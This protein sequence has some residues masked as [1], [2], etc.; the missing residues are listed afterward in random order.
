VA[1]A[2]PISFAKLP[3]PGKLLGSDDGGSLG[4]I[5]MLGIAAAVLIAGGLGGGALARRNHRPS[6]G[7]G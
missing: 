5:W 6:P 7:A 3:P 4:V 2:R 1:P